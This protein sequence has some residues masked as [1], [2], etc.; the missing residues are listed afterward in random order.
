MSMASNPVTSEMST[1]LESHAVVTAF[2]MGEYARIRGVN[3]G[4]ETQLSELEASPDRNA[5]LEQMTPLVILCN[6]LR[7]QRD[8]AEAKAMISFEALNDESSKHRET[9][10]KLQDA[11]AALSATQAELSKA[12]ESVAM[13]A[14]EINERSEATSVEPPGES[15]SPLAELH[16][17]HEV[18]LRNFRK[19]SLYVRRVD[20]NFDDAPDAALRALTSAL[21]LLKNTDLSL[22]EE[23]HD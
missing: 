19:L 21:R 12:Q 22:L 9:E 13:F 1:I 3:E 10:K 20:A 18:L 23:K 16:D 15:T 7:E 6:Q 11:E 2:W 14:H 17:K 8:E 5:D 4:L